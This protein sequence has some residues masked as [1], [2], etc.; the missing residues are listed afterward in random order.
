MND[1]DLERRLRSETGPREE[2]YRAV[3]LPDAPGPP[4]RAPKG[5]RLMQ[6]GLL[7]ATVGAG[8][9]AVAA[10]SALL[11][12]GTPNGGVGQGSASPTPTSVPSTGPVTPTDCQ[13]ADVE[14]TAEPWGGAAGSRGTIVTIRL[15]EGRYPCL[16][17]DEPGA[18]LMMGVAVVVSIDGLQAQTSAMNQG[19]ERS[20]A[21]TWSNWCGREIT[22]PLTLALRSG[23]V[24][25]PVDV[26]DG[27]N[28][29]PPCNGENA[30][31]VLN[32]SLLT[33]R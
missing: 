7:L 11:N 15:A 17:A 16:F 22:G 8:V 5:G 25:F 33:V 32:V 30:P 1:N 18:Q 26:P 9:L 2:G 23:G 24:A 3:P 19:D 21:V 12:P 29:V 10:A 4:S 31:S 20:V 14:L 6:A 28:P 13:P 27:A